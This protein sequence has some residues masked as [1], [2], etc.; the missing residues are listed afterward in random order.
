MRLLFGLIGLTLCHGQVSP[1][2]YP[3]MKQCDS[4]W[5]DDIMDTETICQVGCLMTSTSEGIRGYNISINN[6]SSNPGVLNEWLR[7]N[8]GYDGSNDLVCAI[9]MCLLCAQT[10]SPFLLQYS[11]YVDGIYAYTIKNRS[12]VWYL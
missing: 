6:V 7:E 11:F 5:G 9:Y 12:K 4:A 10:C 3:L 2:K 8:G 1:I